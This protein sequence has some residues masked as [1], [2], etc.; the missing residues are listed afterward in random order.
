MKIIKAGS[1]TQLGS[2]SHPLSGVIGRG[3][4]SSRSLSELCFKGEASSRALQLVG[5]GQGWELSRGA[6]PASSFL[7]PSAIPSAA[8]AEGH[9]LLIR[10]GRTPGMLCLTARLGKEFL[11]LSE[12]L[13][14]SSWSQLLK[15][16]Q[17][18]FSKGP[19]RGPNWAWRSWNFP[20]SSVLGS[21]SCSLKNK[22]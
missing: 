14:A 17:S 8:T 18:S 1:Y 7:P 13:R 15:S 10:S 16:S 19:R 12:V 9:L 3:A 4:P 21:W 2:P 22:F 11:Y 6:P 20:P 5:A